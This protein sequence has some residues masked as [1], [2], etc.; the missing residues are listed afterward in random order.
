LLQ[1][2][3][4]LRIGGQLGMADENVPDDGRMLVESHQWDDFGPCLSLAR[5]EGQ[6]MLFAIRVPWHWTK[7]VARLHSW[8]SV[9]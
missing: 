3:F 9:V 5:Q 6:E 1:E 7:L 8:Y 4:P 2:D